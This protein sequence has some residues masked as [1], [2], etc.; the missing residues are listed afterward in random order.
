MHKFQL[1]KQ[2]IWS[3]KWPQDFKDMRIRFKNI[4][5]PYWKCL[6]LEHFPKIPSYSLNS[7]A[8]IQ[9]RFC[10]KQ[11]T[12]SPLCMFKNRMHFQVW[13]AHQP[14]TGWSK[15]IRS[16][17]KTLQSLE[18]SFLLFLQHFEMEKWHCP[19]AST[20]LLDSSSSPVPLRC[21]SNL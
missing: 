16:L 20:W 17:K 9:H 1:R 5:V 13:W 3:P 19:V 2:D 18:A 14:I 21:C 8:N 7:L 4:V 15:K 10:V 12:K 11:S 6:W